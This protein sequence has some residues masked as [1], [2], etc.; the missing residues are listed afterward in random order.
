MNG[1]GVMQGI[2]VGLL[3]CDNVMCTKEEPGLCTVYC[4]LYST[5]I[6]NNILGSPS[7]GCH[8][9]YNPTSWRPEHFQD[10]LQDA[11]SGRGQ[12]CLHMAEIPTCGGVFQ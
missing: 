9:V 6:L 8:S 11:S 12:H 2:K 1:T 7:H 3:Q 5:P 10:T 4:V